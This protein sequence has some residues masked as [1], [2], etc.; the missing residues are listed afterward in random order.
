MNSAA[1]EITVC[2][3]ANAKN[4]KYLNVP[5]TCVRLCTREY[6]T[7][8]ELSLIYLFNSSIKKKPSI[9][10]KVSSI[11]NNTLVLSII[12]LFK[13]F[14][15]FVF[16]NGRHRPRRFFSPRQKHRQNDFFSCPFPLRTKSGKLVGWGTGI[17][18]ILVKNWRTDRAVW[19]GMLCDWKASSPTAINQDHALETIAANSRQ[20]RHFFNGPASIIQ[21]NFVNFF[22][23]FVGRRR[24]PKAKFV[25]N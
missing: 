18:S 22:D 13:T 9:P 2:K 14:F 17:M 1:S 12:P 10:F 11:G 7:E 3:Q 20:L 15:K 4:M 21:D 16:C 19:T 8:T 6:P 5:S 23:I 25:I 24:K